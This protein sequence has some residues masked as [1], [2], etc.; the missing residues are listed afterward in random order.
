MQL[1]QPTLHSRKLALMTWVIKSYNG[2]G[3]Y[4]HFHYFSG[5]MFG[6]VEFLLMTHFLGQT[7]FV[8]WNLGGSDTESVM[9]ACPETHRW[10][11]DG[12]SKKQQ[13]GRQNAWSLDATV[14]HPQIYCPVILSDFWTLEPKAFVSVSHSQFWN[15]LA[16]FVWLWF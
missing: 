5:K 10:L 13:T 6:I 7:I 2:T 11:S 1:A 8:H 15:F 4:S 14:Q 16:S 3:I 12:N 9:L